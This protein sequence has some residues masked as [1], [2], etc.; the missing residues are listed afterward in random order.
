MEIIER[1]S[2][3]E[4]SLPMDIRQGYSTGRGRKK[5]V[6]MYGRKTKVLIPAPGASVRFIESILKNP[7]RFKELPRDLAHMVAY[8]REKYYERT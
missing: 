4:A 7:H 5:S 3:S 6:E 2:L 8:H 1:K